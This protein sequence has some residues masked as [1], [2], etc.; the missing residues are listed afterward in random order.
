M[1]R[2]LPREETTSP[3]LP[4]V[5][6]GPQ[7]T[8]LRGGGDPSSQRERRPFSVPLQILILL[9]FAF[10]AMGL[11][12]AGT[13]FEDLRAMLGGSP[14]IVWILAGGVTI[15]MG[16]LLT[17][18]VAGTSRVQ[19]LNRSALELSRGDLSRPLASKGHRTFVGVAVQDEIDE[20]S[21]AVV[22]MQENLRDL[23]GHIQRTAR[24]VADSANDLG[25]NAED[26]N[27]S[28]DEV[29]TSIETIAKGAEQ[30][31][32]LVDRAS[33]IISE[34]AK[35][36]D[37]TAS[38]AEDAARSVSETS[39]AAH[40]GGEVARLAGEKVKK[41]FAKIETSSEQVFAFGEKTQ[42]ISKIVDAITQV[43][44]QT[45]LLALNATI[46][47]ARAGEY[48]RGFAVVAD[49]VRKLAE[50]A[51]RSAEQ[52]SRLAREINARSSAVVSSMKEGIAELEEGRADLNTILRSLEGIAETARKGAEKVE[53][54]TS[55]A[56]EQRAGSEEMVAAIANIK[57]LAKDNAKS[58]EEVAS[59]IQEQTAAMSQ[60]T[61]SAQ[62][63]TNLSV[64]LQSVVS[65]FRL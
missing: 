34:M 54:I 33:K 36:I 1:R 37:R 4:S 62:E 53:L 48:G 2:S 8:P 27:A 13:F 29:A 19:S 42:E 23:V 61:S 7:L 39:D 52:I 60:M 31:N 41:V 44:Q 49:E 16:G 6:G 64:E 25:R 38:S 14:A 46:E 21:T 5:R 18:V 45:N 9:A 58:T 57:T 12:T 17:F 22:Q 24:S 30:Q 50:S 56:R 15:A 55:A 26:V 63:L 59:A 32:Q 40:E 47:A 20:L 28:T 3:G 65:R 43:A 10:L 35:S 11:F 51:G